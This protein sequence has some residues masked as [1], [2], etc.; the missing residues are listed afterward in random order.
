MARRAT[1]RHI[2]AIG[3]MQ[4]A[5]IRRENDIVDALA[6]AVREARI[7]RE[8]AVAAY[9]RHA[10]MHRAEETGMSA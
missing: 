4:I 8:R 2:A 5:T 1:E 9:R 7:E 3:R 6:G 10:G